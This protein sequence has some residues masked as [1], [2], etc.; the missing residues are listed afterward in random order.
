VGCGVGTGC[1]DAGSGARF[2]AAGDPFD[3]EAA[4]GGGLCGGGGFGASVVAAVVAFAWSAAL[5]EQPAGHRAAARKAAN[6]NRQ[7]A[8]ASGRWSVVRKKR[9]RC[10]T[11]DSPGKGLGI[12]D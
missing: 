11:N 3:A 1:G 6:K 5:S 4:A 9:N 7:L 10:G 8:A 2:V 12:R